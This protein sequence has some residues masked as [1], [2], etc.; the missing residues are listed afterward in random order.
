[1]ARRTTARNPEPLPPEQATIDEESAWLF[2]LRSLSARAQSQIEIERKLAARG[3]PVDVIESAIGRAASYGY[4]DDASLAGQLAR[5]MLSRGYGR[6][7]A[8]RKL[9]ERGLSVEMATAAL[10]EAY[11]ERDELELARAALGRR[12]IADDADR[13]RAV[14][15]LA[16][17]G[18]SAGAAWRA[19]R[20]S[21]TD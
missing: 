15:F 5:G 2:V 16:R 6:R 19:V 8:E 11:G 1:M 17:R 14:A 13:R 4:V 10:E 3:V 9:R 20:D 12:S 7:R 21:S 18:F